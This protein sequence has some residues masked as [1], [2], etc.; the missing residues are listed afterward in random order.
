MENNTNK[1]FASFYPQASLL[2]LK[3]V[4]KTYIFT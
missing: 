2:M 3:E 4:E 1:Y